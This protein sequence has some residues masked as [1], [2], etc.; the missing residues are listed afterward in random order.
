[1]APDDQLTTS[2]TQLAEDRTILA[3]ERTFAGWMRTS[4]GSIAIGIGFHALFGEMEP[5]WL[6]RAVA[7]SF[8]LLA[9]AIILL[10]ER[11]A[12]VVLRRL[13]PHVVVTSKPINLRLFAG[14]IVIAAAILIAAIW[15]A[16]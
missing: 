10:A 14:V 9:M 7:T 8:L 1:M 6:P 3:N 16:R 11:R 12:A 4:F 13:N 15:L 5:S 2:R